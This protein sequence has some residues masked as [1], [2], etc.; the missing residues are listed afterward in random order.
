MKYKASSWT[1]QK[2]KFTWI[3]TWSLTFH[4]FFN[5]LHY[6]FLHLFLYAE[7]NLVTDLFFC[8]W[9]QGQINSFFLKGYNLW[10]LSNWNLLRRPV[11]KTL[12]EIKLHLIEEWPEHSENTFSFVTAKYN[13]GAS[14]LFCNQKLNIFIKVHNCPVYQTDKLWQI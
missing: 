7:V 1:K 14:F 10:L 2:M 3:H 4:H 6:F 5:L 9:L 13:G 8:F 11:W 12:N